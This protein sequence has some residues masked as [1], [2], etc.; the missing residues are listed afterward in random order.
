[1]NTLFATVILSLISQLTVAQ[2]NFEGR[3]VFKISSPNDTSKMKY[4]V[5]YFKEGM[6]FIDF[7]VQNK[8]QNTLYDFV[9]GNEYKL[10]GDSIA[11]STKLIANIFP[12]SVDSVKTDT[13]INIDKYTCHR[14][15]SIVLPP[16]NQYFKS[17]ENWFPE[18][19]VFETNPKANFVTPPLLYFNGK[20]VALKTKIRFSEKVEG[21]IDIDIEAIAVEQIIVPDAKFEIPSHMKIMS[22]AAY[23]SMLM[24]RFKEIDSSLDKNPGKQ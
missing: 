5:A 7:E 15:P 2:K 24:E 8:T 21:N 22:A 16:M 13:L 4:H 23:S 6:V 1:M 9:K 18:G 19:L 20:T 14:K 10:V 3:I 11:V 17:I 12:Y